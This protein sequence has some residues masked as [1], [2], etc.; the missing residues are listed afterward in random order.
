MY[1]ATGTGYADRSSTDG[2]SSMSSIDG[3]MDGS[4]E[5]KG[6][7]GVRLLGGGKVDGKGHDRHREPSSGCWEDT[8]E[9]HEEESPSFIN[10][11]SLP[12]S[13]SYELLRRCRSISKEGL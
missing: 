13:D 1:I 6:A 10:S 2:S 12:Q 9:S 7:A 3:A 11:P 8:G 4:S 5:T